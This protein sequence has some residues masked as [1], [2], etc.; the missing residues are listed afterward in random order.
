MPKF[1][2]ENLIVKMA[3][4]K[5]DVVVK[6][7]KQLTVVLVINFVLTESAC[8]K[9]KNPCSQICNK[10][11]KGPRCSCFPG[12]TLSG[13]GSTCLDIN[14]LSRMLDCAPTFVETRLAAMSVSVL[15]ASL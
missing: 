2:M 11:P 7:F 9:S 10:T 6:F 13:D 5:A 8:N 3:L 15:K 14:E 12:Y 4:M 1:A